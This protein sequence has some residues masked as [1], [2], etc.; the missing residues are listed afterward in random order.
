MAKKK[1]YNRIREHEVWAEQIAECQS[2][3]IKVREWCRLKGVSFNTYYKR[4][5]VIN[6]EKTN[7]ADTAAPKIVPLSISADIEKSEPIREIQINEAPEKDVVDIFE[8]LIIRKDGMMIETILMFMDV[9][10]ILNKLKSALKKYSWGGFLS[11]VLIGGYFQ[12]VFHIIK[13]E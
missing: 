2:S 4:L 11:T 8:K 7:N 5:N 9:I 13:S 6:K 1:S 3:G 10:H 12:T